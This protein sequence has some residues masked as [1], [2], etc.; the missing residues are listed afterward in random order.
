MKKSLIFTIVLGMLSTQAAAEDDSYKTIENVTVESGDK[1]YIR[2]AGGFA[3][4]CLYNVAYFDLTTFTGR[5]QL[6]ILMAAKMANKKVKVVYNKDASDI[7]TLT[8]VTIE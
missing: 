7:C 2:V 8:H 5:G 3:S 6:S 4:S 1:G